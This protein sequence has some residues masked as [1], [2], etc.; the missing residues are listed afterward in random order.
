MENQNLIKNSNRF[1]LPSPIL[2][3]NKNIQLKILVLI[4]FFLIAVKIENIKL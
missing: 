2:I 4:K 3:N 1:N